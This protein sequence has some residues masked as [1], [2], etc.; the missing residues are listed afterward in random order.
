M[1]TRPLCCLQGA[2]LAMVTMSHL[3]PAK[4]KTVEKRAWMTPA[5]VD[6]WNRAL[7]ASSF[8]ETGTLIDLHH[9]TKGGDLGGCD[10]DGEG[11][12]LR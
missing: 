1:L 4:L 2:W 5:R 9:L 8:L 3:H 11:S 10:A 12:W 7:Q 6:A